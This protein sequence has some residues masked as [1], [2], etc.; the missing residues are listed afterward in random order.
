VR[1]TLRGAGRQV[2]IAILIAVVALGAIT[3]ATLIGGGEKPTLPA[4]E[5]ARWSF[6]P[7]MPHRRSYT[8]SAQVDGRVYVAAGMVGNSGKPLDIFERFDPAKNSW[9]PLPFVPQA[10]SAAAGAALGNEFYLVGGS[11]DPKTGPFGRQVYAYDVK[12]EKWTRKADLPAKRTNLAAVALDGKVYALGGLDPFFASNSVFVYDPKRDTWSK[13]APLPEAMH[14]LAA[15]TFHGEI[16]TIGGQASSGK[17]TRH[18]WIYDPRQN[19]W[20]AG[21]ATPVAL[22]TAGA[23]VAGNRIYV[24]LERNYLTYDAP[25]HRWTR[26]PSLEVPR[27]ALA[28]YAIKGTLYAMGGCIVPQLEDSSIVEKI[29]VR[30]ST[31]TAAGQ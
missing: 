3:A 12:T 11:G 23:S 16:W 7:H 15:V 14:A 28:V 9:S 25:T 2:A 22:E 6:A 17:A 10:F 31:A 8:A 20:R 19:R 13:S 27:H 4:T 5:A 1:Q 29:P 30:P 18:V 24:V 26:G 21:P